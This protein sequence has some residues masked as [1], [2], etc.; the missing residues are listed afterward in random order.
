MVLS[1]LETGWQLRSDMDQNMFKI[2]D[3]FILDIG[4]EVSC[5]AYGLQGDM[6]AL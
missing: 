6:V 1:M 4:W 2:H 3:L 5:L